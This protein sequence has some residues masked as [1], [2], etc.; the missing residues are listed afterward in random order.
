M[1]VWDVRRAIAML[2][3]LHGAELKIEISAN[4]N[5]AGVV[6]YASLFEPAI[7][8]TDLFRLSATHRDGPIFLNVMRIL[9]M[10]QALT[11]AM[12]NKQVTL[13]GADEAAWEFPLA[14]QRNLGWPTT[15]LQI[16]P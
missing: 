12:E 11:I 14:V 8:H 6:L 1:R 13:H 7:D 2:R 10:P 9:D 16:V 4:D 15:C 5:M 3:E